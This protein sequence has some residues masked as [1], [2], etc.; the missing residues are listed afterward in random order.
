MFL[1]VTPMVGSWS[2]DNKECSLVLEDNPL[3]TFVE[4]PESH[5]GLT[6]CN[7]LCGVLRG[8][9]EM[10]QMRVETQIVKDSLKGDEHTE[11]RLKLVEYLTDEAPPGE[12]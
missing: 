4:L 10:V 11:L 2:S 3:T 5:K 1:G 9:L 8:A 6:Y 7:L 12:D